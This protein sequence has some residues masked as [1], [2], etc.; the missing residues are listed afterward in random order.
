M[1]I[2]PKKK[3][4]VVLLR[5]EFVKLMKS[6]S[7]D[8]P[9]TEVLAFAMALSQMEFKQLHHRELSK[10]LEEERQNQLNPNSDQPVRKFGWIE[11]S[12]PQLA[13][14]LLESFAVED[15]RKALSSLWVTNT[16]GE[17]NSR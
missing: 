6:L 12:P 1:K 4:R 8:R 14:E 13:A 2:P 7:P 5:E 10:Y 16:R 15:M 9:T 17:D 3:P 11:M